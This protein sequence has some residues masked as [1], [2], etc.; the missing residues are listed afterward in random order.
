MR[1]SAAIRQR[2]RRRRLKNAALF[3]QPAD[4]PVG[5][6]GDRFA[7]ENPHQVIDFWALLEQGF[8]LTLGQTARYDHAPDSAAA[9]QI[10]HLANRAVRFLPRLL[11]K[12]AGVDHHQVGPLWLSDESV[13][14]ELQQP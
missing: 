13:P 6:L 12:A 8:L 4:Q 1:R 5:H 2:R 14:I 3:V 11:D 9:I 7:A 10:E